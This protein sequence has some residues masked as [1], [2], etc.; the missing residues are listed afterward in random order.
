M[1]GIDI[2]STPG[3]NLYTIGTSNSPTLYGTA[4]TPQD[5]STP[6]EDDED[7]VTITIPDRLPD[8]TIKKL[9]NTSAPLFQ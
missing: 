8:L 9:R 1:N 6:T 2:D 3:S 5:L 4:N 7:S